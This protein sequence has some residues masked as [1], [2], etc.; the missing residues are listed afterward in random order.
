[1]DE[2]QIGIICL[3]SA[4]STGVLFTLGFTHRII[5]GRW[6]RFG[7]TMAALCVLDAVLFFVWLAVFSGVPH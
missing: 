4:V 1:V 6:L 3:A 7:R 5:M 2:N